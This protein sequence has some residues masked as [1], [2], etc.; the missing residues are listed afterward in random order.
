MEQSPSWEASQEIPTFYRTW[1]FITVFTRAR[2]H[3]PSLFP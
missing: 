1:R 3:F 2:P